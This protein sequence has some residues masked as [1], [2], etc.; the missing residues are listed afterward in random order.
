M[1]K[2]IR[3]IR[4]NNNM[5]LNAQMF[6]ISKNVWMFSISKN[7]QMFSNNNRDNNRDTLENSSG[8]VNTNKIQIS[9]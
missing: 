7:A 2:L 4:Q 8:L 6:S 5:V 9:S 1:D 3:Y